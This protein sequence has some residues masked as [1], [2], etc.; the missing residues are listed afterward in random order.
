MTGSYRGGGRGGECGG[1]GA[2]GRDLIMGILEVLFE[3][4][5]LILH[6]SD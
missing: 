1:W 4:P 5:D 3:E 2:G 6:R